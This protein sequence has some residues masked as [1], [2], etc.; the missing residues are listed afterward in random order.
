MADT[1]ICATRAGEHSRLV[2]N[3]AF[4]QAK[5]TGETIVFLHVI[6]G[7]AFEQHN[8]A[9]QQAIRDEV[10][11]LVRTLVALAQQRVGAEDVEIRFEVREGSTVAQMLASVQA[12]SA[13]KM[14]MG[15]PCNGEESTF[16]GTKMENL[17]SALAEQ[18]VELETVE[19]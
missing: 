4:E 11:W 14:I 18:G 17:E 15:D 2:H 19:L 1:I 16:Q 7:E 9:M 5:E 12:N 6:G 3:A 10:G 13:A 8:P